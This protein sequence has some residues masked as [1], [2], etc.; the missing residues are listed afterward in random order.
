M[1]SRK[2]QGEAA[3]HVQ[4]TE[5]L[6][7]VSGFKGGSEVALELVLKGR[8]RSPQRAEGTVCTIARKWESIVGVWK[9]EESWVRSQGFVSGSGYEQ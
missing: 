5:M 1:R 7:R 3:D 4:T 8:A 6:L 9:R 2:H